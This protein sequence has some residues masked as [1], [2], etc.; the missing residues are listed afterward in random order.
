MSTLEELVQVKRNELELEQQVYFEQS[1]ALFLQQLIDSLGLALVES[2]N[3][4]L[5]S[6]FKRLHDANIENIN[7]MFTYHTSKFVIHLDK[8]K[9]SIC[10]WNNTV[11]IT[12][13]KTFKLVGVKDELITYL[14]NIKPFHNIQL[15]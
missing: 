5:K 12:H 8:R 4:T 14:S 13:A 10:L 1:K 3:L 15:N 2:M 6:N 11:D 7:G 9:L